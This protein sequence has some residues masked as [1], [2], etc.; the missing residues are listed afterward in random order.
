LEEFPEL[1]S[2]FIEANR[3]SRFNFPSKRQP[4]IVKT[5]SANTE[6]IALILRTLKKNS[7]R[8]TI[9]LS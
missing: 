6:S 1:V 4:N 9:P 3:N 7:T 8:E 2:D 5:I